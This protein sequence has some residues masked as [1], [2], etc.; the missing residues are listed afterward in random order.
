MISVNGFIVDARL[1]PPEIQDEAKRRGLIPDPPVVSAE[2]G[3]KE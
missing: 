2:D 3:A 1:M